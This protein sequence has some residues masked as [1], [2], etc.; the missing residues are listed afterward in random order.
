MEI[1]IVRFSS[2]YIE[3]IQPPLLLLPRASAKPPG[4]HPERS[5]EEPEAPP[6]STESGQ[7]IV[8]PND[9]MK[10]AQLLKTFSG[11]CAIRMTDAYLLFVSLHYLQKM[12][13][14]SFRCSRNRCHDCHVNSACRL[15]SSANIP[16]QFRNTQGS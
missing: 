3:R 9:K 14:H 2:N 5:R 13:C 4:N 12:N 11:S 6:E 16:H 1:A 15:I 7:L 8:H 10:Y